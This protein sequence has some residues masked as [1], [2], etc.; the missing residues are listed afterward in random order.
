MKKLFLLSLTLL[1][2]TG[3]GP[4]KM[5]IDLAEERF[6]ER[7]LLNYDEEKA[8]RKKCWKHRDFFWTEYID[9]EIVISPGYAEGKHYSWL[10]QEVCISDLENLIDNLVIYEDEVILIKKDILDG[11]YYES[12]TYM[13]YHNDLILFSTTNE[14]ELLGYFKFLYIRPNTDGTVRIEEYRQEW[15][16]YG[17]N[18]ASFSETKTV[19]LKEF[20][21]PNREIYL[22]RW[23]DRETLSYHHEVGASWTFQDDVLFTNTDQ[24]IKVE[25]QKMKDLFKEVLLERYKIAFEEAEKVRNADLEKKRKRQ[26]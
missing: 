20:D 4:S 19:G 25:E 6:N 7:F 12:T 22:E 26:L 14:N 11:R 17:R 13:P 24:Y 8:Q 23:L 15:R 2:V 5:E 18:K 1:F 10:Y 3:C 16:D 9:G 21:K